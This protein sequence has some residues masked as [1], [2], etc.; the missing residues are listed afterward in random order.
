M[1]ICPISREPPTDPRQFLIPCTVPDG[2]PLLQVFELA[3]L[4]S[5]IGHAMQASRNARWDVSHPTEPWEK[6]PRFFA[7]RFIRKPPI[8]DIRRIR[9]ERIRLGLSLEKKKPSKE[10]KKE[11]AETVE[12]E[13]VR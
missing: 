5:W 1:L 6:C 4:Y 10:Q 9:A 8:K 13:R 3:E 12:Q 11:F 7:L 2:T